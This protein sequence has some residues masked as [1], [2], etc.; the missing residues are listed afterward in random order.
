M[1]LVPLELE[2]V[3]GAPQPEELPYAE[4]GDHDVDDDPQDRGVTGE[5]VGPVH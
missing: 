5:R 3:E 4:R 1:P 2:H